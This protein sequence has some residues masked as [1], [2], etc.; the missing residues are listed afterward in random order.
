MRSRSVVPFAGKETAAREVYELNTVS[1]FIAVTVGSAGGVWQTQ[2]I[3]SVAF[4]P[5]E[6][7][8]A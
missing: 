2:R 4:E 6:C 1:L 7:R 3:K 5:F 8:F